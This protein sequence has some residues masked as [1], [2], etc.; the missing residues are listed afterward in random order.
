MIREIVAWKKITMALVKRI[1]R[2]IRSGRN[3][4][5]KVKC[6][7]SIFHQR[8]EKI[9][10]IDTYGSPTRA[11]PDDPSQKLQFG[12]EGINELKRVLSEYDTTNP[13]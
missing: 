4:H 12:R 7:Y 5:G 2:K 13:R 1:D 10:Q 9:L 8:G 6:T 3:I 11:N